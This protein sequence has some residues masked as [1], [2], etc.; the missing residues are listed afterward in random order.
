MLHH[1]NIMAKEIILTIQKFSAEEED[2]FLIKSLK[3]IQ[4]TLQ[5]VAK[6]KSFVILYFDDEQRFLKTILLGVNER[7][8]WLDVAPNNEDNTALLNSVSITAVTMHNGAKVQFSC[9]HPVV[10]VYASHPALYFPL[11]QQLIR[12]QRRDYFRI[13]TSV[14]DTPIRCFIPRPEMKSDQT[15]EVTIMDISLGGIALRCIENSVR[16]E[17]GSLYPDCRIELPEIGTLIATIQVR[18][19]FDIN[20]SN[21]AV[22]KHAG[23]EFV[24]LDSKMSMM[25]QNYIGILQSKLSGER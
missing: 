13:N 15:N 25:L 14:A 8:I 6:K 10:A 4:L 11:P 12:V 16:L 23:C 5:A 19:L 17:E 9:S 2:K 20:T 22:V 1:S 3:E 7:G 24:Q 18:N 21:G